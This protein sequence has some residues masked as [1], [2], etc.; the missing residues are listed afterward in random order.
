ME[1]ACGF[2]SSIILSGV[3]H[4]FSFIDLLNATKLL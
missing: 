1:L 2:F 3:L 4:I